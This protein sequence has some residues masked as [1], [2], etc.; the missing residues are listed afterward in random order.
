MGT[1]LAY[2]DPGS[3][4]IL[5]QVVSGGLAGLAVFAKYLWNAFADRYRNLDRPIV[6]IDSNSLAPSTAGEIPLRD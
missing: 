6:N 2:F 4:S 5:V 3:G 1:M